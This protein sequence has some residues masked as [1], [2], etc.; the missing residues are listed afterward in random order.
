VAPGEEKMH[1]T[2]LDCIHLIIGVAALAVAWLTHKLVLQL[3]EN[4]KPGS[5]SSVK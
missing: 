5:N 2:I 1:M 3:V 4:N